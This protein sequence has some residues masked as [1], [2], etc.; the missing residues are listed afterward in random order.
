MTVSRFQ[1]CCWLAFV[2]L[3]APAGHAQRAQGNGEVPKSVREF[4]QQFYSWYVPKALSANTDPAWI[5]AV[6]ERSAIFDRELVKRLREDAAA[7]A[8]CRELVG[9]DFDPFLN[10]QDPADRYEVKGISRSGQHFRADISGVPPGRSPKPDV[11]VDVL[12]TGARLVIVNFFY[13][14]GTDLMTMLKSPRAKCELP[15]S[16]ARK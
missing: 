15:R 3:S 5:L 8:K 2:M 1:V 14:G 12:N 4:V 9:L 11:S 7:Q 13:S 6:N 10:S 16:P